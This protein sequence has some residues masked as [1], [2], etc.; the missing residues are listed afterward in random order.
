MSGHQ[1][2]LNQYVSRDEFL[3]ESCAGK[4]ILHLGCV[5][6]TDCEPAEKVRQARNSLHQR[7]SESGDCTGVDLDA[8]SIRQ[9]QE[10]GVFKNV[11][12]GDVEDLGKLP[13]T[14]DK[15]DVVVAGDI[16]EHLSNPGRMLDGIKPWLRPDGVLI[17]TT[18]NS[19]G[20]PAFLRYVFGQFREGL[21][22]VLCFNPIT[23]AQLLER[24]GFT[25]LQTLSCH[26]ASAVRHHGWKF[27]IGQALLRRW[28]KYGGTL[29]YVAQPDVSKPQ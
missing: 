24:H 21:Q 16:I 5:G 25:L 6:F 13:A 15:F 26:Q 20:L 23:L 8:A 9:L 7:L 2:T 18:P 27:K 1:I 19:M 4:R 10:R 17:I 29:L 3:A 28:P 22:H 14:L 11:L 12:V